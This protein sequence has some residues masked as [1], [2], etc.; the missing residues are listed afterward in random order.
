M[1]SVIEL[2]AAADDSEDDGVVQDGVLNVIELVAD[3]DSERG[4]P[5]NGHIKA[6]SALADSHGKYMRSC[7][8]LCQG[9]SG[10]VS[11][12]VQVKI[13]RYNNDFATQ[14][15][16]VIGDVQATAQSEKIKKTGRYRQWTCAAMARLCFGFAGSCKPTQKNNTLPARARTMGGPLS[17]SARSTAMMM[18]SSSTHVQVVR[19]AM[20]HLLYQSACNLIA[21]RRATRKNSLR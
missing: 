21:L 4:E 12:H 7:R 2:V 16:Q 17:T 11:P 14:E 13:N 19:N 8:R 6:G 15:C 1:E 5:R 9:R 3:M 10:P 20:A 18:R